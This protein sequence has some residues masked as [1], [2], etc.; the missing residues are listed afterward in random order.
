MK[1]VQTVT[2]KNCVAVYIRL[3]TAAVN[4]LRQLIEAVDAC[5]FDEECA[6]IRPYFYG[7]IS[8][9]LAITLFLYVAVGE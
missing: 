4:T 1:Q 9:V 7:S 3:L 6:D 8:F 5:F 2:R